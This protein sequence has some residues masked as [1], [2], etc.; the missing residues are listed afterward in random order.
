M[1]S[2]CNKASRY[3]ASRWADLA[4]K[5]FW[6]E[7]N[8]KPCKCT[9]FAWIFLVLT[10]LMIQFVSGTKN[11]VTRLKAL[12]YPLLVHNFVQKTLQK[13]YCVLLWFWKKINGNTFVRLLFYSTKKK[14]S[15]RFS[16]FSWLRYDE[17]LLRMTYGCKPAH[18]LRHFFAKCINGLTINKQVVPR[19]FGAEIKMY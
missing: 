12:L 13:F 9:D 15:I 7:T 18:L 10:S 14:C 11:C 5:R 3:A 17:C 1:I 16:I 2:I 8:Q 6:I 4:Y 19:Y